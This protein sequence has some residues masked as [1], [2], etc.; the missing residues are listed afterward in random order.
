MKPLP[1]YSLALIACL[2]LLA[3]CGGGGG[4]DD[5]AS[6]SPTPPGSEHPIDNSRPPVAYA[7][8]EQ[9]LPFITSASIPEDGRP[10]IEFQLT[11]A[12]RT[13]IID[14]QPQH[15]RLIISKL[16]TSPIGNLSGNWQ[17]YINSIEQPGVGPGQRARLQASTESGNDG[18]LS[19]NRDGTYHYRFAASVLQI[20]TTIAEQARSE[21]L[22]LG[23]EP[24]RTHRIAMQFSDS[25]QAANPLYDWV[26]A[27][28]ATDFIFHYDVAATSNCNRCHDKLA[29][30]GGGR[31]EMGYCVTCHNPG[32]GDA[33]SGNT[34]DMRVMIH[35]LHRGAELPSVQAGG[36]YAIWGYRDSKHDYSGLRYPQDI[37]NCVNCHTGTGSDPGNDLLQLT[38]QGDNWNQHA[39]RAACG[40]CHDDLDFESHYGGQQDDQNCMS[41]H[42][43]GGAAGTIA[44]SHRMPLQEARGQFQ[45][46]VLTVQNTA[47][48]QFPQV[49][50]RIFNPADDSAYDILNDPAWTQGQGNSRLAIGLAWSTGDY[51]NTGNGRDDA[52]SISVDALAGAIANGDGSFRVSSSQAIPD[53]SLPPNVPAGGSGVAVIEGHPAMD[54]DGSGTVQQIPLRNSAG[55]FSIDEPNAIAVPRRQSV[56]LDK[57]LACHQTL[58]LHGNNRTDSIES[59]VSCHN[60]RN[61]DRGVREIASIPPSDGKRE[62]SLDFKTMVHGIHAAAMRENPL[63]IVGFRGSST[64]VYDAQQVHYPGRLSN[65]LAC[66][67]EGAYQVPLAPGVLATSVDTGADTSDPADDTVVTPIAAVCSSCH[68]GASS[69]AHMASTGNANFATTQAAIDSGLVNEQCALCHGSGTTSDIDAVHPTAH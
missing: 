57:C 61:T 60:P 53:G 31:V 67:N 11:D 49:S 12:L 29:V 10:V 16:Q 24:Q 14:L 68:D 50:F 18:E 66:H 39:S 7:D 47:P 3:N 52:S 1:W 40:S 36:E 42:G 6:N 48:G 5:G 9:I 32:S 15:I 30:H 26:P 21:G 43:I 20:D 55:F 27:S 13:A 8:A 23:Y 44:A 37:R 28:G 45:A 69:V 65:C 38:A 22:D 4:S 19:N 17:S 63:Q 62:E 2:G 54:I 58:V 34:V 33:N 56:T 25:R 51:S 35:K 41:C 46:E 64:H 59:C